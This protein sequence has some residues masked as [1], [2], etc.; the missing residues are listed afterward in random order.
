MDFKDKKLQ[1]S[2]QHRIVAGVIGG[3]AEYLGV[4]ITATRVIWIL[5]LVFTGVVPGLIAYVLMMLVMPEA[6][7]PKVYDIPHTTKE[8]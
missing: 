7:A 8:D 1:R 5:I 4:D 6:D 2:S 3:I